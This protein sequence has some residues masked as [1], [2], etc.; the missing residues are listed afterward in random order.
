[1]KSVFTRKQI[2]LLE[3]YGFEIQ[4]DFAKVVL[5]NKVVITVVGTS[6][7]WRPFIVQVKDKEENIHVTY[8]ADDIEE[9]LKEAVQTFKDKLRKISDGM[10]VIARFEEKL[11][12]KQN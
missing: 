11:Q 2:E 4:K 3:K 12:E 7:E 1:M 6:A 5:D 10:E 8:N 9:G